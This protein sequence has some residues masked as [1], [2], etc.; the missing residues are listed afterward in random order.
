MTTSNSEM[1][2]E[3][4]SEFKDIIKS[5]SGDENNNLETWYEIQGVIVKCCGLAHPRDLIH[6]ANFSSLSGFSVTSSP[7]LNSTP[8]ITLLI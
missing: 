5:L 7:S 4:T 3:L 2:S 6:A 1:V 8:R